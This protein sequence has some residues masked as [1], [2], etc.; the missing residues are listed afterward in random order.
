MVLVNGTIPT[1]V[2]ARADLAVSSLI[3]HQKVR[4]VWGHV[5]PDNLKGIDL[6]NCGEG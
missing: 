6:R 4:V 1:N 2:S 5:I 3:G